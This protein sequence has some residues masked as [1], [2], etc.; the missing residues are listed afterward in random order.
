MSREQYITASPVSIELT[1]EIRGLDG[2]SI[3]I[4]DSEGRE[5]RGNLRL[6]LASDPTSADTRE[7]SVMIWRSQTDESRWSDGA[8]SLR[9]TMPMEGLA[10]FLT[11]DAMELIC[12]NDDDSLEGELKLVLPVE[13]PCFED[14]SKA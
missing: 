1:P 4:I 8:M 12:P 6:I 2:K 11:Q 13:I 9:P 3:V 7:C 14:E 5:L 10:R